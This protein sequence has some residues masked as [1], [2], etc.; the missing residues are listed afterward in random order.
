MLKK[1]FKDNLK[2]LVIWII[3]FILLFSCVYVIYPSIMNSANSSMMNE[4]LKSFPPEVVKMFNMD[5]SNINTA[6][7]WLKTEGST[8]LILLGS[9]YSGILG[10]TILSKEE[11]NKTIEYLESKPVSRNKII[12]NKIICGLLNITI[13]YVTVY[14]FNVCGMKISNDLDIKM[15][16]IISLTP[17]LTCY[18][19]FLLSMFISELIKK[20]KKAYTVGIIISFLG[21]VLQILSSMSD[22]VEFLKYITPFTL[23]DS[24]DLIT[25]GAIN[26]TSIIISILICIII[27]ILIYPVYNKK[28]L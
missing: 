9:V 1:E 27:C 5:I 12:T 28:D 15:L 23:S 21:Y 24:R 7:G 2:S 3:I 18:V 11:A 19:V 13:M 22:K 17:L 10:A 20:K 16:T 14:L 6:F 8:F 25:R 4:M 26:N